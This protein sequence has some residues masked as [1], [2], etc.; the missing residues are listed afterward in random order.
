MH[1]LWR[2]LQGSMSHAHCH[3]QELLRAPNVLHGWPQSQA[4][5]ICSSNG[6]EQ[7]CVE[8]VEIKG[9]DKAQQKP[10]RQGRS[11]PASGM[12]LRLLGHADSPL[13]GAEAPRK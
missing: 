6:L 9:R 2:C 1:T 12:N 4:A 13:S 8:R 10:L 3:T 11:G 5:L 7:I